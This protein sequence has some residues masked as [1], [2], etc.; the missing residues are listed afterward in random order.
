[1]SVLTP[2]ADLWVLE[3]KATTH[4]PSHREPFDIFKPLDTS[5]AVYGPSQPD[6]GVGRVHLRALESG[7]FKDLI[8]TDELMWA[9]K[10]TYKLLWQR[11][12]QVL[13]AKVLGEKVQ[14]CMASG[15]ITATLRSNNLSCVNAITLAFASKCGPASKGAR[16]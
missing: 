11:K 7:M 12:L 10:E 16:A 6:K 5:M 13:S 2:A 8:L 1:M 3:S 15:S 9:P 4:L 14:V